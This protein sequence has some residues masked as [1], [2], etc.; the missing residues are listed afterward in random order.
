MKRT[1]PGKPMGLTQWAY[2]SIKQRIINGQYKP[3][4]QLNIEELT[5]EM[6]ISRTPVREALLRLKEEGLVSAVPRVGFF[7]CG[8]TREEFDEL[9]ELR[10]LIECYAAEQAASR[11]SE[12]DLSDLADLQKRSADMVQKG[13]LKQFNKLEEELHGRIIGSLQN[14]RISDVLGSVAD[15]LYKE[16]VY[17]M[18]SPDNVRQSVDE[19]DRIIKALQ[20]RNAVRA[21]QSMADH[22]HGVKARLAEMMDF[23]GSSYENQ[24]TEG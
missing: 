19:H 9:F 12:K 7:V 21:R 20:A 2:M 22:L 6:G 11:M 18:S 3:G 10:Q 24:N 5:A 14:H 4:N 8:M 16:R 23:M 13:K 1:D 17:A 15:L